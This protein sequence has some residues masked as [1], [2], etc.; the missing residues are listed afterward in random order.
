MTWFNCGNTSSQLVAV[1][2][3]TIILV[4][5]AVLPRVFASKVRSVHRG[6]R[7]AR[8]LLRVLL[9]L[10]LL[11]LVL[12]IPERGFQPP[13]GAGKQPF[14]W[15][16]NEFWS[17]L[18]QEFLK[19]RQSQPAAVSNQFN[20]LLAQAVKALDEL[21][22]AAVA[23]GNPAFAALEDAM[24]RLGPLAAAQPERATDFAALMERARVVTKK[25]SERWDLE[26]PRAR[27]RLYRVLFGGRMALD[28]VMVQ[29]PT[30]TLP[31]P[32]CDDEPS[33]TPAVQVEGVTLHS[34]DILVSRG[35]WPTSSF[36]ARGN[37]YPGNFSHVAL[38][39][40]NENGDATIIESLI[41]CGVTTRPLAEFMGDKR[42]RLMALRPRADLPAVRNDPQLPH[43][44]AAAA[45]LA[46]N[47]KHIPYDFAM[48]FRDHRAM[49]CSEVAASTYEAVNVRLW[50]GMT[51]ISSP[52][53][54]AWLSS[55]GVR[56]FATQEP[57]DLEYDPQLRVVAE[58]RNATNVFQAHLDDAVTDA[59]F[60]AAKPGAPLDYRL[61]QLP[62]A[63]VAKAYSAAK[64]VLGG[65]GPVPEGMSATVA[66][67]GKRFAKEHQ[68][69]KD[70]LANLAAEFEVRKRYAPPYWELLK[71]AKEMVVN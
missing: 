25:Q 43:R 49:F 66:L 70:R 34:G 22:A 5:A 10:A 54:T 18:E 16:K 26:D 37:D 63:R 27:E 42:L 2:A 67:R 52:T 38:L 4:M 21:S 11:Y 24:F 14:I 31:T 46:A 60:D 35:R 55:T 61:L 30:W 44:A 9:G 33:A 40:V 19:A 69:R 32:L 3:G 48:D 47:Q 36:I 6:R 62:L 45:L 64:N 50:M 15:N 68:M 56:H 71:M 8:I 65:I 23:P 29:M 28:E 13:A 41:E 59:M 12:L 20:Q 51:Y 57:S 1:T 7:W 58:W 53:V 17:E 39:H